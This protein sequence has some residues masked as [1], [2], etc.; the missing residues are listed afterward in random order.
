MDW[1]KLDELRLAGAPRF[2]VG[3][4]EGQE[5]KVVTYN[6]DDSKRFPKALSQV[7]L[8][9]LTDLQLG[10]KGFQRAK[11]VE[12]RDWVLGVP[13]RF[14]FL[15]GDVIDAATVLSIASPY[16]NTGE[17]IDQVD[18]AVEILKP[19]QV[20]GRLL[21]YVGG[22]HERRTIKTFGD[23]G[24]LIARALEVPYSRGVQHVDIRFGKHQP[25]KVSLWH[26]TGGAATKGTLAQKLHRLMN[27]G[28]SQLYFMGH[29]HQAM[30]LP[31]WRQERDRGRIKLRKIMG[32]AS[33]SFQAWWNSYAE[34]AMLEPSETM[35]G[36]AILEPSGHWE[37]TLR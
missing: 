13:N 5:V 32:V 18:D 15:G 16:D 21:G 9:H 36:R 34:V 29:H 26:G 20:A 1:K 14:V 35:M 28:D 17:P 8:L 31:G 19:L 4:E 25:F 37:V 24:R 33:T 30:V 11:F 27:K 23:C 12:Y 10:S 7:E 2:E 3:Q 6:F 22:N